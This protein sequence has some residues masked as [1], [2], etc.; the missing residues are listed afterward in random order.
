MANPRTRNPQD[1]LSSKDSSEAQSLGS[2]VWSV[3]EIL[4]GGFRQSRYGKVRGH[5]RKHSQTLVAALA[6]GFIVCPCVAYTGYTAIDLGTLGGFTAPYSVNDKG[7]VTGYSEVAGKPHAFIYSNGAMADLGTLGGIQSFG[8][9]INFSGQIVGQFQSTPGL[10]HAFIYSDGM[11][12]A[13]TPTA[14][15]NTGASAINNA[16]QVTGIFDTGNALRAFLYTDGVL[17]LL[18][19]LGGDVAAGQGINNAGQIVGYS[20]LAGNTTFHAFLYA[21][22]SISDLGTLG[23]QYSVANA[24]NSTGQIVGYST[25][26]FTTNHHSFLY[27]NGV[28]SDL[29]TL[30]GPASVANAINDAGQVVGQSDKSSG[31]AAFLYE[32]GVMKDLNNLVSLNVPLLNAFGINNSGQIVA[33]GAGGH[34]YLLTPLPHTDCTYEL[35]LSGQALGPAGGNGSVNIATSPGCAWTVLNIPSWVMPTSATSGNGNGTISYQVAPNPGAYRTA[36]ITV[37]SRSFTVEQQDASVPG[38]SFVGSLAHI[39]SAGTWETLVNYVNLGSTNAKVRTSIFGNR[40]LPL[41]LPFDFPQITPRSGAL[42]AS[43]LDRTLAPGASLLMHSAGPD[44]QP[45]DQGWSSIFSDGKVSGFAIFTNSFYNWNAVVP[46]EERNAASYLLPFDNTGNI[47]SGLAIANLSSQDVNV[48]VIIRDNTGAQIDSRPIPLRAEGHESFLLADRYPVVKGKRGTVEFDTPGSG[49]ISVLGLRF[50]GLQAATTVPVLA[51]VAGD[52]GSMAHVAFSGGWDTTFTVVNTGMSSGAF[53]L[54]FYD[55]NG[56]PLLLPLRIPP[57]DIPALVASV[58]LALQPGAS[59]LLQTQGDNAVPFVW[60]SAV[61]NTTAA[62]SAHATFRWNTFQQEATV[63]LETRRPGSLVIGFDNTN[64][65]LAGLAVAEVGGTAVDIAVKIRDDSGALIDTE[66]L[67]LSGHGHT[68]FLLGERFPTTAEKR[69]TVEFVTPQT[70]K[71]SV[72]GMRMKAD[73]TLTTIPAL[74]K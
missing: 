42:L 39:V 19:S 46:L 18:P 69:G 50:T 28:M 27:S 49:R 4:R 2:F 74:A 11:M 57:S 25:L 58:T 63:P 6:V 37:G 14:Q 55:D 66:R 29:G 10:N 33:L 15:F 52:G 38:L 53:T 71:L 20:Y 41:A 45:T 47:V 65:L 22:V 54:D 3:A 40:G 35:S 23:G 72:L 60:G 21:N 48:P 62:I 56:G 9:S 1:N 26:S 30:G 17:S 44:S 7:D 16:A 59:V 67:S 36:T 70:G 13:L 51:N 5:L 61:L 43:S 24:I 73:G 64:G 8:Q 31:I 34:A 32:D 12:T 68:A